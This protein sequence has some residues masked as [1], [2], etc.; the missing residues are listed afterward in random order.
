MIKVAQL[1]GL[2]KGFG[3]QPNAIEGMEIS[4][5]LYADDSLVFCEADVIKTDISEPS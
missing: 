5:L 3:S 4:Q 1:N 2:I